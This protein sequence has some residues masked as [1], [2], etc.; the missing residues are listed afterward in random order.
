MDP[1]DRI[2]ATVGFSFLIMLGL[3]ALWDPSMMD[4]YVAIGPRSGIKRLFADYWG[5]KL[6][7]GLIALGGLALVGLHTNES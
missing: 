5:V 7:L 2:A 6:G 3:W 1:K 4:G